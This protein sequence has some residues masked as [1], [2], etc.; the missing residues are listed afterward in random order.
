MPDFSGQFRVTDSWL[1]AGEAAEVLARLADVVE[2]TP[3]PVGHPLE[4]DLGSRL[5]MRTL[6]FLVPS[7]K[8]PIRVTVEVV[9]RN[10]GSKV[11]VQAVS[12]QGWYAMSASRF[13][14]AVYDRAFSELLNTLRQAAPPSS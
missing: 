8:V 13:T 4:A 7:R 2:A 3:P 12:N 6:G 11:M 10:P 9:E 14:R 5:S 1:S